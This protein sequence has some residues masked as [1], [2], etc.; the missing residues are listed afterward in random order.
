MPKTTVKQLF[1]PGQCLDHRAQGANVLFGVIPHL[2]C[3]Q[4]EQKHI[5]D[6][7][8]AE[9]GEGAPL[10][11]YILSSVLTTS[12]KC[13]RER[14]LDDASTAP[15]LSRRLSRS[16]F[17][18]FE[19]FPDNRQIAIRLPAYCAMPGTDGVA[20]GDDCKDTACAC[21]PISIPGTV[22]VATG[23]A[24]GIRPLMSIPAPCKSP[25]LILTIV[26]LAPCKSPELILT[27][28][29]LGL[30]LVMPAAQGF[31]KGISNKGAVPRAW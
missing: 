17:I 3:G 23:D 16:C 12:L 30:G 31:A 25:E 10:L 2:G 7:T 9:D 6:L 5:P 18:E 29:A 26:A 8:T 21:L 14:H 19:K 11:T 28:V 13:K 4:E 20:A 27:I 15:H 22:G 1:Q 24:T